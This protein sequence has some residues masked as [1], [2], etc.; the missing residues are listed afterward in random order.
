MTGVQTCALPIFPISISAVASTSITSRITSLQNKLERFAKEGLDKKESHWTRKDGLI[1]WKDLTYVPNDAKLREDVIIAN[2]DHPIAG[3][4]GT[5][6]TRDLIMSE[7]YWPSLKKDIEAYVK[8]CDTCQKV[9]AKTTS[10]TTPLHPNEIPSSPWE[11]ISIDLIGPLP[12][13]DGKN[14]ILVVVD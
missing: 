4:P 1:K 9:K 10:K 13:S 11:I 14:A 7:Y 8:G 2:H 6:R 3:H 5:K 12:Q